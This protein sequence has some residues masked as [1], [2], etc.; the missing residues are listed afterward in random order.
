MAREIAAQSQGKLAAAEDNH[1]FGKV[2]PAAYDAYLRGLYFLHLRDGSKSA[3]YFRQAISLDPVYPAAYAGLADALT[4]ERVLSITNPP[5]TEVPAM[6]AARRAIE[7]DPHSGEAYSA[8]GF[9]E[10]TYGNN[11]TAGGRDLEKGLALS[12]NNSFAELQYSL[13]LDA[14]GRP[15]EAVVHMH[16]GLTLDPLSFAMNRHLGAVLYFARQYKEALISLDHAAEIEPRNFRLV[17]NWRSRSYEMLGQFDNAER[18][19]LQNLSAW[20]PED[21]LK[22]LRASHKR[23]G[24]KGYQ[25]ARIALLTKE[26]QLACGSYEIGESYLRLGDRE[27]AFRSIS[28]GIDTSCFWASWIAVDPMLDNLRSDPR[29]PS[30]LKRV[31]LPVDS[32]TGPGK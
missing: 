6:A 24:W 16:R 4:S 3:M 13:F 27:R 15:E 30:L 17:E 10:I 22:P 32:S 7:L 5:D 25:A 28:R 14:V 18:A 19:D 23:S 21:K 26:P 20:V 1:S 11:W 8:L 31:N 9:V 29:Y 2:A 12:P